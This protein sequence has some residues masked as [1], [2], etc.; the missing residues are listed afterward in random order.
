MDVAER[1][2]RAI[3]ASPADETELLWIED[4]CRQVSSQGRDR[5]HE[6]GLE[7]SLLVRVRERG[8]V[9]TFRAGNA[10]DHDVEQA[11]RSALA[12]ARAHEPLPGLPHLPGDSAP[13]EIA[14][15]FDVSLAELSGDAA[16]AQLRRWVERSETAVLTWHRAEVILASSRAALHRTTATSAALQVRSGRGAESGWSSGAARSLAGLGAELVVARARERR[17]TE[18]PATEPAALALPTPLWLSPEAAAQLVHLLASTAFTAHAYRDGSSFLRHLLGTQVFDRR[19]TLYDDGSDASGLPFPFD[20]EGTA[21]RRVDLIASGTPRTP[22]LDQRHAALFGLSATGHAAGGDDAR[23]E[24][25]FLAPGEAG[26]AEL[27]GAT[28]GGV[29]VAALE[30]LR[31][32]PPDGSR[33]TAVARGVRR[34]R[35]DGTRAVLPDL[36]WDESLLRALS[37]VLAVGAE[38]LL[39]APGGGFL[40]GVRAPALVIDAVTGLRALHA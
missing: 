37:H 34:L 29:F 22:A 28:G 1:L 27:L 17:A 19:L 12:Q 26:T 16:V 3:A 5:D 11:I 23:A 10:E 4:R 39:S 33:F 14:E 24:N 20:L 36:H 32:L 15:L 7:R 30:R 8:R 2:Q 13:P 9:G 21:K 35:P 18:E 38:T 6:D 31:T 40:G 25:L